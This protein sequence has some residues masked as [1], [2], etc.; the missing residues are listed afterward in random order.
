MAAIVLAM[1]VITIAFGE[2]IGI[3]GGQGWDGM[4]YT[5]W[6]QDFDGRVLTPGVTKFYAQR[7]L[8]SGVVHY[9]MS[10]AGVARAV[11]NVIVAFMILNTALLALGAALWAHLGHAMQW[12]RAAVWAGFIALFA[13]F[14]N[15][16]HALYYPTLT[17]P[18]AFVL[19]L[20]MTWA[21]LANRPVALWA[22]AGLSMITWPA[23]PPVAIALL[24]FPRA[25]APAADR[26]LLLQRAIAIVVALALAGVFVLI[27]RHCMFE[28]VRGVGD[29]K[30]AQWVR[31]DLLLITV[32]GLLVMLGGGWYLLLRQPRLWNVKGYLAQLTRR[33]TVIVLAGVAVLAALR[34]LW[35]AKVGTLGPGPTWAQFMCEHTLSAIR[36]PLW[37]F[38]HQVVYFGPIMI[39][40]ALS[41]R[42]IASTAAAWGPAA[43]LALALALAFAAGGNS[44]QWNHLVPFVVAATIAV[45]HTRWTWQRVRAFAVLALVWSKVW[46]T[47]GYDR[48]RNWL[49]WPNQRYY[50]NHGP[51]ATDT[52][53]LVHLGA[54]AVTGALIYVM[55][56]PRP[57][58]S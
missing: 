1:G 41:W 36:G 23:L 5:R 52:M 46:L 48:H 45:T 38:V 14:A 35:I 57:T 18:T 28:P 40:A 58:A 21:Y 6:A 30:F 54:A 4:G 25:E 42:R 12:R 49:E 19:G 2:R 15:L 26:R 29:E 8:P 20:A 10:A 47:I 55:L 13:S 32:P 22:V 53:Y 37:G 27:A 9:A 24:V 50:M 43:V 3:N 34:A 44:R 11:P 16:R 51:Y 39:V 7:V 17:D 31:R 33:R 56:R